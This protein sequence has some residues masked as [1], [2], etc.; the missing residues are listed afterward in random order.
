M[1]NYIAYYRVSTKQ[2][3][4]SGLGLD[5]QRAAVRSFTKCET[6]IIAEYTEIESGKNDKREQLH[7]AIAHAKEAGATLIIA[8]L[9]RLSRNASFIFALRD[10]GVEFVCADMP[11]ANTLTIGIFALLAQHERETISQR[12]KAA[13][14]AAKARGVKLGNPQNLTRAGVEK[15]V[16]VRKARARERNQQAAEVAALL[17]EKGLSLREIARRLNLRG[18]CTPKGKKFQAESVSRLLNVYNA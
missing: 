5:A 15:S 1:K 13:L 16:A 8:K 17:R 10:S 2:Q 9:D 11:D 12:T 7:A 14:Q 6:C 4:A 3:G 18:F